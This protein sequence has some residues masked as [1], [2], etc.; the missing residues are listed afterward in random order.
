[1]TIATHVIPD[2]KLLP[3][4]QVYVCAV[5]GGQLEQ[6]NPDEGE[7][8]WHDPEVR[9]S[10]NPDH[11]GI[12]TRGRWRQY[13]PVLEADQVL[14]AYPWLREQVM[15]PPPTREQFEANVRLL[16]GDPDFEGFD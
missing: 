5:C 1:M 4:V 6:V 10:V 13:G 14:R 16:R 15:G 8:C 12:I 7:T 2:W 3:K 9:C 11:D